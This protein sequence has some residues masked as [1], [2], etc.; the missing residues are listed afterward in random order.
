[1]IQ[2]NHMRPSKSAYSSPLHMVPKKGSVEWRPVGDHRALN[3]QTIKEKYPI[4]C[5]ADFTSELH[6]KQMFSHIDLIKAPS[7]SYK[8]C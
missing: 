2:L 3:A 8:S 7:N 6:G 1:M 5:I 4:P